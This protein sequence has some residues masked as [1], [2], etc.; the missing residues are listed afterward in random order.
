MRSLY[1]NFEGYTGLDILR[2][3]LPK[4]VQTRM[5]ARAWL[6]SLTIP[7][8]PRPDPA[9]TPMILQ[10]PWGSYRVL[11]LKGNFERCAKEVFPVR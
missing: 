5:V 1:F 2:S 6:R 7:G 3:A 4:K 10:M 8:A 11:D 9:A